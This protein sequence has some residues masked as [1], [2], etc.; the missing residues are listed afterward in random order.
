VYDHVE[1]SGFRKGYELI[2]IIK[3]FNYLT[4]T[5]SEPTKTAISPGSEF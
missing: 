1:F 3:V 4:F 5:V 2:I